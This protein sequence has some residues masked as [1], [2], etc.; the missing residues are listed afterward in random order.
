MQRRILDSNT[1]ADVDA[2]QRRRM[3]S[4]ITSALCSPQAMGD[5]HTT[6]VLLCLGRR[7]FFPS[8]NM[9][10]EGNSNSC[11]ADHENWAKGLL[12]T[13]GE[14]VVKAIV[15]AL[16]D[17]VALEPLHILRTSH[18]IFSANKQYLSI[19]GDYLVRLRTRIGNLDPLHHSETLSCSNRNRNT[20][21]QPE[22]NRK[23]EREV[24]KFVSEFAKTKGKLCASLIR[25][26]NF[27]RY[28]F[29]SITLR[30]LLKPELEP[31]YDDKKGTR[32]NK[33]AFDEHRIN[34]IKIMGFKRNDQAV[35]AVEARE[36][37]KNITDFK[38]TRA[39]M[40][41]NT[42]QQ[43]SDSALNKSSLESNHS[44]IDVAEAAT[45]LMMEKSLFGNWE[46]EEATTQIALKD[47]SDTST[48]IMLSARKE[49]EED[50]DIS[51][52]TRNL[53]Q[54]ILNGLRP[55]QERLQ[56]T[57]TDLNGDDL[58]TKYR[59]W[60]AQ[61]GRAL[62]ELLCVIFGDF[63][64]RK[65]Q[66]PLQLQL[67]ALSGVRNHCLSHTGLLSLAMLTCVLCVSSRKAVLS[68]LYFVAMSKPVAKLTPVTHLIFEY[69]P[70]VEPNSVRASTRFAM[71]CI[72]LLRSANDKMCMLYSQAAVTKTS[73][74]SLTG[75][76]CSEENEELPLSPLLNLL[77]WALTSPWRFIVS[78]K[79]NQNDIGNHTADVH[80]TEVG[81][82]LERIARAC[83]GQRLGI[84]TNPSIRDW[85]RVEYRCGW[86]RPKV[87][88]RVL[89]NFEELGVQAAKLIGETGIFVAAQCPLSSTSTDWI[90]E[91]MRLFVEERDNSGRDEHSTSDISSAT[92]PPYVCRC[93]EKHGTM[94][95]LRMLNVISST[96]HCYFQG[97]SPI[98]VDRHMTCFLIPC[99][100][101][102]S[103]R[104]LTYL[105]RS[106]DR[107]YL[108][109][110]TEHTSFQYDVFLMSN[111]LLKW[112]SLGQDIRDLRVESLTMKRFIAR[113]NRMRKV[114]DLLTSFEGGFVEPSTQM[115]R[116]KEAIISS[117]SVESPRV[118]G[119]ALVLHI[120]SLSQTSKVKV[121]LKHV[122][123]LT[124][125]AIGM[126]RA[127]P[128]SL[129]VSDVLESAMTVAALLP[130]SCQFC[131]V[132]EHKSWLEVTNCILTVLMV[133]RL[134]LQGAELP[135]WSSER[136]DK[137]FM[138]P[139]D[140]RDL[141]LQWLGNLHYFEGGI[142]ENYFSS[143]LAIAVCTA[144]IFSEFL[145]LP[146]DIFSRF[147]S[148]INSSLIISAFIPNILTIY[149]TLTMDEKRHATERLNSE[150]LKRL[151]SIRQTL[152]STLLRVVGRILSNMK[153]SGHG[154]SENVLD[155][156]L[157]N[158]P[159]HADELRLLLREQMG[160]I[161]R[162]S[163]HID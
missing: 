75:Q 79:Q 57:C 161:Q 28:H 10:N 64:L 56:V 35:T 92:L 27:H 74:H 85:L 43:V 114:V 65:C 137:T 5:S 113:V 45:K 72:Y 146:T 31:S 121:K 52:T 163:C 110:T 124:T 37:I 8:G 70:L 144:R 141:L 17:V 157:L 44:L 99:F 71:H 151:L 39:A 11:H 81:S 117:S 122:E 153:T 118:L 42:P 22:D 83:A 149:R 24:T 101:P 76:D 25:Q 119:I 33:D 12:R 120:C 133:E 20:A 36:A 102:F 58:V 111:I 140:H 106:I 7:L 68:D 21:A 55:C 138:S 127:V 54:G 103:P 6:A 142:Q 1:F 100:W 80:L 132:D 108:A 126:L 88:Q 155:R 2:T 18:R 67:F 86:G 129:S 91:G 13:G 123:S 49:L 93:I 87:V 136:L 152:V 26:M 104:I 116:S 16:E 125:H 134:Q 131:D 61:C 95:A 63:S 112:D 135:V 147:V 139:G 156:I 4:A 84:S 82:L 90:V 130:F 30:A 59:S 66:K 32:M 62:R 15:M 46:S 60:W 154:S 41:L 14:K 150:S 105:V 9:T 69:L 48:R 47:I 145:Q 97:C 158:F 23:A 148:N 109:S 53:L 38:K 162:E 143:S 19:C 34:M 98:D 50:S 29:R 159:G 77:R 40:R 96:P 73:K 89:R 107:I 3:E 115:P 94:A 51:N 128:S 78:R 160:S